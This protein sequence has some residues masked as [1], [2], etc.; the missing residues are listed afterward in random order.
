MPDSS[1]VL[2]PVPVCLINPP[3]PLMSAEMIGN[4]LRVGAVATAVGLMV[5]VGFFLWARSGVL[6]AA[7]VSDMASSRLYVALDEE[8]NVATDLVQ[9]DRGAVSLQGMYLDY[10]DQMISERG[11]NCS[12]FTANMPPSPEMMFF[13]S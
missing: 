2:V 13:V 12:S 7:E 4:I 8:R 6:S 1:S 11:I 9:F 5:L 3:P 10:L